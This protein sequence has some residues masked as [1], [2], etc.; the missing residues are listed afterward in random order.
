MT[1]FT[2][3]SRSSLDYVQDGTTALYVAAQNGHFRVVA[4]L[5]AAKARVDIQEEVRLDCSVYSTETALL[6]L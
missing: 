3:L 2:L 4:F 1:V 5:I 6:A